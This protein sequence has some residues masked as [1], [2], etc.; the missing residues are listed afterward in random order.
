MMRDQKFPS[1]KL[2]LILTPLIALYVISCSEV[3]S[4]SALD[5]G[6]DL[7]E[8]N[9]AITCDA[10]NSTPNLVDDCNGSSIGYFYHPNTYYTFYRHSDGSIS[11]I[12][13]QRF[14]NHATGQPVRLNKTVITTREG[15]PLIGENNRIITRSHSTVESAGKTNT[16]PVRSTASFTHPSIGRVSAGKTT[17]VSR[18]VSFGGRSGS[19]GG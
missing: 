4:E 6:S 7:Y 13:R 2:L 17:S 9:G 18:G 11:N 1:T 16:T 15:A 10:N 8:V 3:S 5:A 12:G 19:F 14:F